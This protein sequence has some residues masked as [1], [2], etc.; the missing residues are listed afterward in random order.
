MKTR[1]LSAVVTPGATLEE[2]HGP[3]DT[4]EGLVYFKHPISG[5]IALYFS[6]ELVPNREFEFQITH[7]GVTFLTLF[8]VSTKGNTDAIY[9]SWN[10]GDPC[11]G[12]WP[13]VL[14]LGE[15][16]A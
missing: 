7:D 1:K 4:F 16:P 11:I 15:S 5:K 13:R 8:H 3:G 10:V 6:F 14:D 12:P 9:E 2:P